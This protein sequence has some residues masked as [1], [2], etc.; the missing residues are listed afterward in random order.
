MKNLSFHGLN[1]VFAAF[2]L[3]VP[4]AAP[5][6]SAQHH[7]EPTREQPTVLQR[8]VPAPAELKARRVP[9]LLLAGSDDEYCPADELRAYAKAA[10]AEVAILEG[11]NHYL[12]RRE[13][14]AATL[15]GSFVDGVLS[16]T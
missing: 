9:T 8:Q 14:E 6:V 3:L 11:T 1:A 2:I 15:I 16:P 7:R 13:R 12:W 5:V 4:V 10:G